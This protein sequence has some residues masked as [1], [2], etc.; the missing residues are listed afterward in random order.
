M[1]NT[2]T[3]LFAAIAVMLGVFTIAAWF[4]K[5]LQRTLDE[6]DPETRDDFYSEAP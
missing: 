1:H 5:A 2:L 4:E 3:Q 6:P